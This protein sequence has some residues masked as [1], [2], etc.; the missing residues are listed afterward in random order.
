MVAGQKRFIANNEANPVQFFSN[1]S[2]TVNGFASGTGVT[3]PVGFIGDA[4]SH[5]GSWGRGSE[6]VGDAPP[7]GPQRRREDA[8]DDPIVLSSLRGFVA[9]HA[10]PLSLTR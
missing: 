6:G 7:D 5:S 3:L 4:F 2:E 10:R 9:K 1:G 8:Y